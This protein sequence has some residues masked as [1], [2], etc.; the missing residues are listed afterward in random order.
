MA[1]ATHHEYYLKRKADITLSL[2]G[3]ILLSPLFLIIALLIL[4]DSGRPV[5]YR[6]TRTGKG[7]IPFNILKFRTMIVNADKSSLLTIGLHDNRITRVGYY[8]R[9]YKIDE[10]PQLINVLKGEMSLVGPRPEVTKYTQ[11]YTQQQKEAL[12]VRPGITDPASIL[13][14]DENEM[15]AASPDPEKFYIEKL[16]PEK[17][18][19]NI[20]Y[21]ERMS[22]KNDLRIIVKTLFAIIR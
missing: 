9:K 22:L 4:A 7:G 20:Q 8:L 11:L 14:K 2:L 12:S 6:Q 18:S 17:V 15:I 10:F 16:I 13:L 5:F 3:L 19:I 1:P 21:I